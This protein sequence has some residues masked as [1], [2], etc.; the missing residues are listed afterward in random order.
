MK[1]LKILLLNTQMEAAGAQKAMLI[2]ARNLKARGH[3]VQVVTMY[4]KA[5]YVAFFSRQY[6][7]QI[8]DLQMKKVGERNPFIQIFYLV[9]GLWLLYRLIHD[10]QYDLVQTFTHY[11]NII[12]PLVARIA[13]TRI[14]ITSQRNTLKGL[15]TLLLWLDRTITNSSL[16]ATMVCVSEGTRQFCINR[17]G[18]RPEKLITIHNSI[19]TYHFAPMSRDKVAIIKRELG[20]PNTAK[21]VLTV[22]RLHPQKGH[23]FLLQAIPGV[24]RKH[25]QTYF[26][27][28]GE[29]ELRNELEKE[30]YKEGLHDVVRF[31]GVRQ[32]IPELLN[33]GDL[34]VLPSLWEGLPNAILEAMA[35][36]I[37]VIATKV[38]GSPEVV[39][40]GKTGILVEA[41]DPKALENAIVYLLD[42]DQLRQR[43]GCEAR[44]W[45]IENFSEEKNVTSFLKL[46]TQ[47]L[48]AM[49]R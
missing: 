49:N 32:D 33:A 18:I 7:V 41:G 2:L 37:P 9:K 20:I 24:I 30:V 8:I 6:G 14:C 12:G 48:E 21:I 31:L 34:F 42:N 4:D 29:G 40:D 13:G 39:Q 17:Q 35:V 47:L 44:K 1:R 23:K 16:V 28:V 10:E 19:D 25:P 46:Y 22:A 27:F 45:V 38:D 43:M 3:Q 15:P 11:S 36:G 5:N 26:L